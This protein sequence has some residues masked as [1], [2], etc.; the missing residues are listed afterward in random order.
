MSE[1]TEEQR[2]K[3]LALK[4]IHAPIVGEVV[5][6]YWTDETRYYATHPLDVYSPTIPV[7]PVDGRIIPQND[8]SNE[9]F[10]A[11]SQTSAINDDEV[12]LNFFDADGHIKDLLEAQGDGIKVK[13]FYWFPEVELFLEHWVAHLR[14]SDDEDA[15]DAYTAKVVASQGFRSF[16]TTL[17]NRAHYS[18]CQSPWPPDLTAEERVGIPCGPYDRDLGGMNGTLD[19]DTGEAW[20]FC[21]H[22]EPANCVERGIDPLSFFAHRNNPGS[23]IN[24]QTHGPNLI[25]T[26]RG[27]E[28][29]LKE[30]VRVV[31]GFRHIRAM[32]LLARADQF[33]NN[34]PDQG[35]IRVIMEGPEG[36]IKRM[37][38]CKVNDIWIAAEH[39]NIR[40]GTLRQPPT[41]FTPGAF[42][43]SLTSHFLAVYGPVNPSNFSNDSIKGFSA[44]EGLVDIKQFT[45]EETYTEDYS[46]N[47]AWQILHALTNRRWGYG[48]PL[49]EVYIPDFIE[50]AEWGD[51]F[52]R[53]TLE[54]VDY[55]HTRSRSDVDLQ[56]RTTQQQI[57]DMCAAGRFSRPFW[58][59]GK[60][61]M[62]PLKALSEDELDECPVFSDEGSPADIN[63]LCDEDGKSTL[64]HS[65]KSDK[66]LENRV[67][68]NFD[69]V[70]NTHLEEPVAVFD[71]AQ[72]QKASRAINGVGR[73]VIKKQYS[74]LGITFKEHAVKYA[75]T[76]L[77]LGEFDEGG[78]KNNLRISF[79]IS[80]FDSLELHEYKVI[81][82]VSS[83]LSR[84]KEPG[85]DD[86]F[87]YFR[88]ISIEKQSN[89]TRKIVAQAYNKSYMDALE[90]EIDDDGGGDEPPTTYEAEDGTLDGG[91]SVETDTD[92]SGGEK[93]AHI[94]NGGTLQYNVTVP[95]TASYRC[96]FYY[97]SNA[98]YQAGIV[99]NDAQPVLVNFP[100]SS[101]QIGFVQ[102][103]LPLEEGIT[104]TIFIANGSGGVPDM[105]KLFVGRN[106]ILI[107]P[108][109]DGGGGHCRLTLGEVAYNE[110]GQLV[111]PINPCLD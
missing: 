80:I 103:I 100:S 88:I 21:P 24:N 111:V 101:N 50:C 6:I 15:L 61:R 45:D 12:E 16:Q 28:T 64:K 20:T 86:S 67:E 26:S 18:E 97:K 66:D 19:P 65:R 25:A 31:M 47:R 107:D 22:K 44:I 41:N 58:H 69:N 37:S 85:T 106:I 35:F 55:D 95:L 99:V 92:C 40:L 76:L 32:V 4:N 36:P 38:G 82:V 77:D 13:F 87:V 78:L 3:V 1:L 10:Q 109:D 79:S 71:V 48:L 108:N 98:D 68:I 53:F 93:V 91:A 90:T 33:N 63:I 57:E 52:V 7:N 9:I 14:A 94:G 83:S 23:V 39:L 74:A 49:G 72:Q 75:S 59:F 70:F 42:N 54:G 27:N 34:H 81:K 8:N 84:Y 46:E 62:I 43:Y 102:R 89:L 2:A 17:P 60:L 11:V 30:A 5:A 73:R 51:K 29:N 104:N 110:D 105:D 56:E 96:Y